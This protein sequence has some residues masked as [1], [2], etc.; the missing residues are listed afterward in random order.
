M[1]LAPEPG[2]GR[3]AEA[4]TKST[5]LHIT[6]GDRTYEWDGDYTFR[7][8]V[9]VEQI[10]G[11]DMLGW[12]EQMQDPASRSVTNI[13]LLLFLVAHRENPTLEWESFDFKLDEWSIVADD[14]PVDP[15]PAE[16]S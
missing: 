2:V 8:A 3:A 10:T 9:L 7:E 5:T 4:A 16:T 6:I 1:G 13:G 11:K 12:L 15:T 14:Q